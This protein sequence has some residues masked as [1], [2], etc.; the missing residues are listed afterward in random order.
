VGRA[1]LQHACEVADAEEIRAAEGNTPQGDVDMRERLVRQRPPPGGVPRV[2]QGRRTLGGEVPAAASGS[3]PAPGWQR[4][5]LRNRHGVDHDC[6][7]LDDS[8]EP[9]FYIA[10]GYVL[11]SVGE[12]RTGD[13]DGASVYVLR[14]Q[15]LELPRQIVIRRPDGPIVARVH[16]KQR[17]R[18]ASPV[19]VRLATET[20]WET[21]GSLAKRQY[22]VAGASGPVIQV[23]QK[24][25]QIRDSYKIHVADGID[26]ALAAA[27]VWAIDELLGD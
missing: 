18:L 5:V 21:S 3:A 13:R 27:V 10:S 22:V 1:S 11:R 15:V 9:V 7:V 23:D 20:E 17:S 6:V 24:S 8:L 12:V 4:L 19:Q 2:V 26:T 25:V 14:G 16:A